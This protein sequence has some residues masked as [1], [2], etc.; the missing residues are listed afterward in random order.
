MMYPFLK[1][2]F[3]PA[4][5]IAIISACLMSPAAAQFSGSATY[6]PAQDDYF[7]TGDATLFGD[8]SDSDIFV[9]KS[10]PT[11]FT[12]LPGSF[13]LNIVAGAQTA[14]ATNGL[15]LYGAHRIFM[16]G[17]TIAGIVCR[18]SSRM[19]LSGGTVTV[20]QTV[21]YSTTLIA[22]GTVTVGVSAY[23]GTLALRG[24]NMG[25]G[26]A[27]GISRILVNGGQAGDLHGYENSLVDV[28]GGTVTYLQC[29]DGS[30]ARI[31][32]GSL[33][34]G[35][36]LFY[37]STADFVGTNL[38]YKYYGFNTQLNRDHFVVY[39]YFTG[40][41]YAV[42]NLFITNPPGTGGLPNST[43]HRFTFNGVAP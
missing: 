20:L 18:D 35:V 31:R 10:G 32:S 29:N 28:S 27:F 33:P 12:T 7:V 26:Y 2:S 41:A 36:E 15:D 37:Y 19:T 30:L 39:G 8:A 34:N 4:A 1:R 38:R 13:T 14:S 21:D 16:T 40:G 3:T 42:Y 43:P 24:G 9:G 17:G 6:F 23:K 25:S 22:S 5:S 11:N